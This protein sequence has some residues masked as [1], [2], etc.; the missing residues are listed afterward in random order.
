MNVTDF[1]TPDSHPWGM[2]EA[3]KNA[4]QKES[5]L[6]FILT[7]CI[8]AGEWIPVPTKYE[9]PTMVSDGL[10][11][12]VEEKTYSLTVKSKG[13]LYSFYGCDKK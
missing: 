2:L 10:L 6:S 1:K 9:H 3:F 7:K 13:L 11:E 12:Q 8:E 5:V 4:S